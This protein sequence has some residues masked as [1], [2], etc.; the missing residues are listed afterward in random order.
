MDY[1]TYIKQQ[2]GNKSRASKSYSKQSPFEGSRRKVRGAVLRYL[3]QQTGTA[4]DLAAVEAD[5][6]LAE[7]LQALQ[8][9]GMVREVAGRYSLA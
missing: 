1:G 8:Q 4:E 3:S 5:P 6:R 2:H 9:E 7:V